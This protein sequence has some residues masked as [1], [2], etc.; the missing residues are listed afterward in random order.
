MKKLLGKLLANNQ[1]SKRPFCFHS[2]GNMGRFSVDKQFFKE[3]IIRISE[4]FMNTY[5][6]RLHIT[7]DDGYSDN[8]E[9]IS[10]LLE[11]GINCTLFLPVG[12]I[13]SNAQRQTVIKNISKDRGVQLHDQQ[14][15][16]KSSIKILNELGCDLGAHTLFHDQVK[17][18]QEW[19]FQ[20]DCLNSRFLFECNG[21]DVKSFA[22][23]Y[24]RI[25]RDFSW[26]HVQIA[27]EHF[28]NV[29]SLHVENRYKNGA[30]LMGRIGLGVG[31][32]KI[33]D[34][35]VR[36]AALWYDRFLTIRDFCW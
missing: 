23:P 20:Q 8:F 1:I 30:L 9:I 27:S 3:N 5:A 15:L 10:W 4:E 14:F 16:N 2:I 19:D 18:M 31:D 26:R 11:R 24:G 6:K 29:Y 28:G 32:M 13:G 12:L 7:F 36:S 34:Q 17:E 25:H 21:F 22:F 35:K 33:W